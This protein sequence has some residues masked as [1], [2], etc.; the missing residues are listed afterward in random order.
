MKRV[1]RLDDVAATY[2][3]QQHLYAKGWRNGTSL[4]QRVTWLEPY[5]ESLPTI[6]TAVHSW[7]E[8]QLVREGQGND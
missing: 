7:I 3:A 2:R 5:D 6:G 1:Q 4:S 8:Q